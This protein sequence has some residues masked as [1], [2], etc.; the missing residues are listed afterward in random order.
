MAKKDHLWAF[1]GYVRYS[2]SRL[3]IFRVKSG[4][5]LIGCQNELVNDLSGS[6]YGPSIGEIAE[7]AACT[8]EVSAFHGL[9]A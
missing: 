3:V 6:N 4:E 2:P 8:D 5:T 9:E 7:D 1:R